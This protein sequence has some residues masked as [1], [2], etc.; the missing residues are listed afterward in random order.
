[1]G[2]EVVQVAP[3]NRQCLNTAPVVAFVASLSATEIIA[4]SNTFWLNQQFS[5]CS[6]RTAVVWDTLISV[7][8]TV[9]A[10][11][12][13]N[14]ISRQTVPSTSIRTTLAPSSASF[15]ITARGAPP[16]DGMAETN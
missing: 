4:P 15:A 7:T 14:S 12:L 10:V 11:T 8:Q 9:A 6:P 5:T 13:R 1:M 3:A 16:K 2:T